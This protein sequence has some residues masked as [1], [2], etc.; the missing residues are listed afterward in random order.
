MGQIVYLSHLLTAVTN[1]LAIMTSFAGTDFKR[2][3]MELEGHFVLVAEKVCSFV[4]PLA[5]IGT[6]V[7][8]QKLRA[9][10]GSRR[11]VEEPF[12]GTL[13]KSTWF[14]Y[15]KLPKCTSK[16][17]RTALTAVL[18]V[19]K[20]EATSHQAPGIGTINEISNAE[21]FKLKLLEMNAIS[22]SRIDFLT[23][24]SISQTQKSLP[25]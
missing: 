19:P 8:S 21:S 13:V 6:E 4:L 7:Y 1:V 25:N 14:V 24:N 15:P 5:I 22:L 10:F 9:G 16:S 11:V 2:T 20:F 17:A 23:R 3:S 18:A 12:P